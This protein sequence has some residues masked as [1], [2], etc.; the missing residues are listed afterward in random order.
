MKQLHLN[1]FKSYLL[2]VQKPLFVFF[3]GTLGKLLKRY[4]TDKFKNYE[5]M[6]QCLLLVDAEA[7]FHLNLCEMKQCQ[8]TTV[9]FFYL[10]RSSLMKREK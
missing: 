5:A 1:L 7:Y 2:H 6:N 10:T 3:P 9:F 8:N 4:R